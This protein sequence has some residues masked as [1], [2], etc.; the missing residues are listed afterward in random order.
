MTLGIKTNLADWTKSASILKI[1]I[2]LH[3]VSPDK[4]VMGTAIHTGLKEGK[5]KEVIEMIQSQAKDN[6]NLM[7]EIIGE[8]L[9]SEIERLNEE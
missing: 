4:S 8:E 3:N 1:S 9:L 7:A 5:L 2:D 6:R